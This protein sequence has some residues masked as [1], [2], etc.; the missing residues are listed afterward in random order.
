MSNALEIN[1]L[2]PESSVLVMTNGPGVR[3]QSF[4]LLSSTNTY[5][6]SIH[7]SIALLLSR[8]CVP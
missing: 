8:R 1:A 3:L 2:M 4:C 7:S 6:L 5:A